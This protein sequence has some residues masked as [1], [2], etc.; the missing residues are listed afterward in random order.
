MR[1][2]PRE[3]SPRAKAVLPRGHC[4][5]A[6]REREA[7]PSQWKLLTTQCG[8]AIPIGVFILISRPSKTVGFAFLCWSWG[9]SK[10]GHFAYS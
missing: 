9:E 10:E 6:A 5:P 7:R 4:S 3:S 1:P 2:K 8:K